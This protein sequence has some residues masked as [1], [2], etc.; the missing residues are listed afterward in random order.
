MIVRLTKL[1]EADIAQAA[2][3]YERKREGLAIELVERVEQ[4][5]EQIAQSPLGYAKVIG[6][7]R[8]ANLKQ[9]PFALWFRVENDAVTIAS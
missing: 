8:R 2:D 6:E 1:A 9:F 3:W 4:T 5:I 7:V